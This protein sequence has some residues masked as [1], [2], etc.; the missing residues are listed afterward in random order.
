MG[1]LSTDFPFFSTATKL[2]SLGL[3]TP[4][5]LSPLCRWV[6]LPLIGPSSLR[7]PYVYIPLFLCSLR[8]AAARIPLLYLSLLPPPWL[9]CELEVLE[10]LTDIF[11]AVSQF[12]WKWGFCFC[13]PFSLLFLDGPRLKGGECWAQAAKFTLAASAQSFPGPHSSSSGW[14]CSPVFL[15]K[16]HSGCPPLTEVLHP[17]SEP[18]VVMTPWSLTKMLIWLYYL[19]YLD[20]SSHLCLK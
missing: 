3:R 10:V 4:A 5:V 14:V 18:H 1:K 6:L 16:T 19:L 7:N 13:F 20:S 11:K 2:G 8:C 15:S 12:C 9:L 17:D